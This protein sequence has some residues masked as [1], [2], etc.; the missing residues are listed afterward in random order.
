MLALPWYRSLRSQDRLAFQA[1][2][3][4]YALDAMDIQ[5]FAFVAPVI[6]SAWSLSHGQIG[7][8]ASATLV[9][10]AMGGW[11]AG[12]MADRCGRVVMLQVTVL[13]F[14]GFS[15]L[16]GFSASFPQLLCARALQGFGFGGE[17]AVGSILV[18]EVV[19]PRYRGRAGGI[20]QSAWAIGWGLAALTATAT[21]LL[22]P[23]WIAWRMVF[24][25]GVLPA[26][27]VLLVR[28]RIVD[29]ELFTTARTKPGPSAIFARP[30]VG[31]TL[32]GSLLSTGIHSGYWVIAIW[33]PT[34]LRTERHL[35]VLDTGTYLAA[36]I[37]GSFVGY[38]AGSYLSDA[39]GRRATFM[40]FAAGAIGFVIAY[41]YAATTNATVL[42]LSFPLGFFATGIYSGI[43][44]TL[45]EIF[46]TELRGA[47]QGFC[48]N[49][50]R[51]VA[52]LFPLV[53]GVG[54]AHYG[55]NH[56]VG[57]CAG[58][59]Y[60]IVIVAALLLPETRGRSLDELEVRSAVD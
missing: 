13:W 55:L 40:L 59:S 50:G 58:L 25:I 49:F 57:I 31:A 16:S 47:G 56:C 54:A 48:Y 7:L 23:S 20:L 21:L 41:T 51:G 45:S 46:P 11:A 44:P 39:V 42:W 35:S 33:L 36:I 19:Q 22:M 8:L 24:F 1:C 60:G 9:A 26:V 10:S 38:V 17:W 53:A 52:G 34:M 12:Y 4:G 37:T 14:A 5:L 2:F 30:I 32:R 27:L 43:G 3:A 18:N 29:S 28:K 15:F 6:M